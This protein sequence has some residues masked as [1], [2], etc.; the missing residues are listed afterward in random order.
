MT[1]LDTATPVIER[2]RNRLTL[3]VIYGILIVAAILSLIP[4]YWM[5]ISSFKP[6]KD[7]L[8]IPVWIVPTNFTLDNYQML[9]TQTLFLRSMF[10]TVFVAS[11][12]V[13]FQTMLCSLA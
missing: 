11:F 8:T 13:I 7:I 6:L 12:N 5:L 10:N 4:F 3:F 2:N 1:M 9:L